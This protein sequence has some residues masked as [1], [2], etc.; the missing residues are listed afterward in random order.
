M[1]LYLRANR[2]TRA[3]DKVTAVV[4][5]TLDSAKLLMEDQV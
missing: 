2:I 5:E 1:R 3:E 4:M